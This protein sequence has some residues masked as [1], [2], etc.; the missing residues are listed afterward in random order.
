MKLWRV[1]SDRL[2]ATAAVLRR[3]QR[4]MAAVHYR[5]PDGSSRS[6]MW[7]TNHGVRLSGRELVQC[8]TSIDRGLKATPG[9]HM[10]I[11]FPIDSDRDAQR[12]ILQSY[13]LYTIFADAAE[14]EV[15]ADELAGV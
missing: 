13:G 6:W 1:R 5:Y 14:V 3:G 8:V 7:R 2:E 15:E 11:D 4:Y 10:R 12:E 9:I